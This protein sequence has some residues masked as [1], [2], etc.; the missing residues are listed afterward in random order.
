MAQMVTKPIGDLRGD[1]WGMD[2]VGKDDSPFFV[3]VPKIRSARNGLL[4]QSL[5]YFGYIFSCSNL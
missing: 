2:G 1:L 4:T 3:F 5:A